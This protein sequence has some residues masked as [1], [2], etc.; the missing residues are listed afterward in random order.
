MIVIAVLWSANSLVV[1]IGLDQF[2]CI[3]LTL[4][5]KNWKKE[6]DTGGNI[7]PNI[8]NENCIIESKLSHT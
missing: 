5:Y 3:L 7:I 1:Y 6:K 2:Q 4:S 8:M